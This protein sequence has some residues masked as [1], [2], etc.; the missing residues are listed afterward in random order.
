MY[1]LKNWQ[2]HRL[3]PIFA[4]IFYICLVLL[5]VMVGGSYLM[6]K[7][8]TVQTA[9]NEARSNNQALTTKRNYLV[10]LPFETNLL[11]RKMISA[12][13]TSEAAFMA[14]KSIRYKAGSVLIDTLTVS[15][16]DKEPGIVLSVKLAGSPSDVFEL[17]SQSI[18]NYPACDLTSL[19]YTL[20]SGYYEITLKYYQNVFPKEAIAFAPLTPEEETVVGKIISLATADLGFGGSPVIYTRDTPF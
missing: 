7:I 9:L 15:T 10:G 13:P 6:G 14:T 17:T 3:F 8:R 18:N 16:S 12:F 11:L 5:V 2:S 19:H 1:T 4:Q 20:E